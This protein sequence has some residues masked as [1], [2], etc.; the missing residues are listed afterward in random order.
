[1]QFCRLI[2]LLA[3]LALAAACGQGSNGLA[4]PNTMLDA[5]GH[6]A[7]FPIAVGSKHTLGS[8]SPAIACNSCHG[9]GASFMEFDCLS[10]HQ[11]SDQAALDL[12][13]RGVSQYAYDSASCYSCHP[14]GTA[15]GA[16]PTGAMSDPAQDLTVDA[17][18]PSYVD[19]SISSVSPLIETL[20]MPMDHA[21]RQVGAAAYASCGN[22]HGNAGAGAYYPGN[23]HSSLASLN[24]PQPSACGGCHIR[25][26]PI[27]L[28][29]RQ[30]RK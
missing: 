8:D 19:T 22:C 12:G 28:T 1:M 13:H 30:L 23:L 6:D 18:I 15:G 27:G 29:S 25:S 24:L 20:P 14:R 17:E 4:R 16:V 10:C 26:M 21:S 3:L 2:V 5:A 9:G 11:H 7:F